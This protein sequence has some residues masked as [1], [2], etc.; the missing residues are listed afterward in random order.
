M[1]GGLVIGCFNAWHWVAKE[2]KAI[3]EDPNE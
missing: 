2:Q 3:W 1:V